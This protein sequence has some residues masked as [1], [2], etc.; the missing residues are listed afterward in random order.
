M[1]KWGDYYIREKENIVF[2][3]NNVELENKK[4][5]ESS[6]QVK[7]QEGERRMIIDCEIYYKLKDFTTKTKKDYTHVITLISKEKIGFCKKG[8]IA[9]C[10]VKD[11]RMQE[12]ESERVITCYGDFL[13]TNFIY[14]INESGYLCLRWVMNLFD[15]NISYND[16]INLATYKGIEKEM[17][18]QRFVLKTFQFSRIC[19]EFEDFDFPEGSIKTITKKMLDEEIFSLSELLSILNSKYK[20]K[21][22]L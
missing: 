3:V 19:S 1:Q 21:L 16:A 8:H 9:S 10:L 7:I 12:I 17:D 13:F 11:V 4:T 20:K 15:H 2:L 6:M 22:I 18:Q 5:H 14:K